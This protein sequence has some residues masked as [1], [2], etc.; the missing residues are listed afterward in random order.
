MPLLHGPF[1]IFVIRDF[2]EDRILPQAISPSQPESKLECLCE[3]P[4]KKGNP[5]GLTVYDKDSGTFLLLLDGA[6][7]KHETRARGLLIRP[8]TA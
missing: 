8:E 7:P 2:F 3:V 6:E 1:R 4:P 5:E